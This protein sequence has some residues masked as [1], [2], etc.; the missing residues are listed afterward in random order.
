MCVYVSLSIPYISY[1]DFPRIPHIFHSPSLAKTWITRARR[2]SS[3]LVVVHP[4][5]VGKAFQMNHTCWW[6]VLSRDDIR[7]D[8]TLGPGF[9]G[10]NMENPLRN[11]GFWHFIVGKN[12]GK[13]SSKKHS[14][15]KFWKQAL[16]SSPSQRDAE[17][18]LRLG[19]WC[20]WILGQTPSWGSLIP[21][22]PLICRST[23]IST[24]P[25]SISSNIF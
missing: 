20:S 14:G 17:G 3:H 23:M 4:Q 25:L 8:P 19:V 15:F 7:G 13:T 10:P 5:L 18:K 2:N 11:S 21:S 24:Y 6:D 12:H 22:P 1:M 16:S 9:S